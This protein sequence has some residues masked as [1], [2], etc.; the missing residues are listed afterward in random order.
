MNIY[1]AYKKLQII[2]SALLEILSR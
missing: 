1:R 2:K